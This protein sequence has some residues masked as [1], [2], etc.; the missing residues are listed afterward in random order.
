MLYLIGIGL[1][2][3]KDLTLNS[4]EAVKKCDLVYLENYTSS[5]N[6][7]IKSLEKLTGKMIITADRDLV[8]N[9]EE[10]IEN[11]KEQNVAFLVKGDIFSA[12]THLDLFLRAKKEKIECKIFHNSS[13]LTAVG[14]TGLSLYKFGKTAS[15]PFDNEK[16]ESPYDI[17]L[18]NGKMHTLFLLDLKPSENKYLNFKDGLNYLLKKS[19]ERKDNKITNETKCVLC[20][21]LGTE[22]E[23]IKYGRIKDLF[24]LNIESYPQCIIMPGELHFIEEEMLNI[25]KI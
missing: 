24:N 3:E 2:N 20:F 17:F 21:S 22:K 8:E 11:A 7:D 6:F 16:I 4:L 14:D 18:E 10:I 5:L 12:T 15:I 13:I 25:F 23:F 19:G 9:S 1:G